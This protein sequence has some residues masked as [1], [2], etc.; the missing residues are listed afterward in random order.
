[1]M[2]R[3]AILPLLALVA[4]QQA[5]RNKAAEVDAAA[6]ADAPIREV[7]T[8]P[9]DETAIVQ[10]ENGSAGAANSGTKIPE[11]LHGRWGL[12]PADCTSKLG[13]AKGLLIVGADTL[14]FYESRARLAR[15]AVATPARLAGEFAFSGE[16][17]TWTKTETLELKDGALVRSEAG[18]PQPLRYSRCR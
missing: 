15:I 18:L 14:T 13:D 2:I 7:A 4:C 10:T 3:L 16:G 9:P 17:Q 1:M 11:G 5:S 6:R 8:L 12:V